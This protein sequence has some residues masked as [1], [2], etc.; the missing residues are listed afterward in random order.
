MTISIVYTSLPQKYKSYIPE[1]FR[2]QLRIG[3]YYWSAL[4]GTSELILFNNRKFIKK[5]I[6]GK[7]KLAIKNQQNSLTTEFEDA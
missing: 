7:K 1:P 2:L 3:H 5:S 4:S 6:Q